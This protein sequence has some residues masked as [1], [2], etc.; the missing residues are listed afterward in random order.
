MKQKPLIIYRAPPKDTLKEHIDL[1]T[2]IAF[3][4][5]IAFAFTLIIAIHQYNR[6]NVAVQYASE[7]EAHAV[8]LE[9]QVYSLSTYKVQ[10][11]ECVRTHGPRIVNIT[12]TARVVG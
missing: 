5:V 12:G 8:S 1:F 11:E 10:Y 4:A 3:V 6:A 9:G 7:Q 2:A